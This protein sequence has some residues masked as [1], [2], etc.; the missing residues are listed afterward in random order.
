MNRF[1]FLT[2]CVQLYFVNCIE[3]SSLICEYVYNAESE[4]RWFCGM[5]ISEVPGGWT[6]EGRKHRNN[7]DTIK[8]LYS[9]EYPGVHKLKPETEA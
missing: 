5:T 7:G 9:S 8:I 2:I 4:N 3:V 1:H 6:S